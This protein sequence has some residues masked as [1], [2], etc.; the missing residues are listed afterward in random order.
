M[1]AKEVN[2]EKFVTCFE[3]LTGYQPY[4][5][6]VRLFESLIAGDDSQGVIPHSLSLPTGTGKTNVIVCWLLALARN[7]PAILMRD[8]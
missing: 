1:I 2:V 8:E 3:Y 4:P 7:K 6:Q 5:W